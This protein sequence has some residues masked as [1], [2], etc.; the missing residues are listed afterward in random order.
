M[1]AI[2]SIH[3][4]IMIFLAFMGLE[5]NFTK[6]VHFLFIDSAT[7]II[8]MPFVLF[9]VLTWIILNVSSTIGPFELSP[10][11]YRIGMCFRHIL[12]MSSCFKSGRMGVT[13]ICT[14][15]FRFCG[16]ESVPTASSVFFQTRPSLE[17][18]S[19]VPFQVLLYLVY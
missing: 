1:S 14:G 10:A 2:S 16:V 12:S 13:R 8:P 19:P 9:L 4:L 7:S 15:L 11:F 6:H 18:L 17:N 3:S 5:P